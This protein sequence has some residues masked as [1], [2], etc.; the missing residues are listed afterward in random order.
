MRNDKLQL[1]LSFMPPQMWDKIIAAKDSRSPRYDDQ[2]I[3]P[4]HLVPEDKTEFF[5]ERADSRD[6]RISRLQRYTA[7]TS[8]TNLLHEVDE[9]MEYVKTHSGVELNYVQPKDEIAEAAIKNSYVA[10]AV[11]YVVPCPDRHGPELMDKIIQDIAHGENATKRAHNTIVHTGHKVHPS[12]S[13]RTTA[14]VEPPLSNITAP[15]TANTFGEKVVS[16]FLL[17]NNIDLIC[18]GH[19]VVN[20]YEFSFANKLVTVFSA[21]NYCNEYANAASVMKVESDLTCSFI[22]LRPVAY[23]PRGGKKVSLNNHVN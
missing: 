17:K 14:E 16:Q 19:Q 10:P 3:D 6:P 1:Q 11:T 2:R 7:V 15:Q 21:P 8:V 13:Q 20:G 4:H 23:L 12:K 22:I 9:T 5:F 18:R